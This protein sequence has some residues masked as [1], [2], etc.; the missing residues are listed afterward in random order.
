MARLNALIK[1]F[2]CV[3]ELFFVLISLCFMTASSLM[4]MGKIKVLSFPEAQYLLIPSSAVLLCTCFGCCGAARQTTRKGCS[5]RKMLCIHQLLLLGVLVCS[6]SQVSSF[7]SSSCSL[8]C[9]IV[10]P[11]IVIFIQFDWLEKRE[12]SIEL[13]VQDPKSYTEYDGFERRLDKKFNSIYFETL[14]SDDNETSRNLLLNFVEEHCPR[15]LTEVEKATCDTTSCNESQSECCPSKGL[16]M[17]GIISACPYYHCR[18]GILEELFVWT[19]YVHSVAKK[20]DT[21]KLSH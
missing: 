17:E 16:C 12:H 7:C 20:S 18:I 14:C 13:V 19:G 4:V 2:F 15:C 21:L 3:G 6:Y 8:N 5:G 9:C 1:L 11:H 10:S